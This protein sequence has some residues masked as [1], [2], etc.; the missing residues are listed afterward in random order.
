ME[1]EGRVPVGEEVSDHVHLA[2]ITLGPGVR[3]G[4]RLGLGPVAP[5][6]SMFGRGTRAGIRYGNGHRGGADRCWWGGYRFPFYSSIGPDG[7]PFTYVPPFP[8]LIPMGYPPPYGPM[9]LPAG[10]LSRGV[11]VAGPWPGD[12]LPQEPLPLAREPSKPKRTDPGRSGQLVTIGDRLF[13]TGNLHRAAERYE[14]ALNAD[15][16]G[17]VPR[18]RLAQVAVVRGQYAEAANRYREAMVADPGW[19]LNAP[20]IESI[21]GEPADFARQVARLET[22]LQAQPNDRD[23]WFVLGAQWY[24]SGQTRKAADVFLRL[25]DRQVDSTLAAF[26]DA[27]TPRKAGPL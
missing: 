25:S 2:T 18:V 5:P 20:D 10:P 22:H 14:Q 9:I 24:L 26:L 13:R 12:V 4:N 11:G 23:G 3:A 6:S 19:L 21:Y 1:E 15:P 7:L 17:A 8:V 16:T 27:T